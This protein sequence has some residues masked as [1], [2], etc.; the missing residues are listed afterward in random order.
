M[1]GYPAIDGVVHMDRVSFA[2]FTDSNCDYNTVAIANNPLSADA[3][4][5][6]YMTGTNKLNVGMNNLAFFYEPDP[7]WIV[8][9]VVNT[10]TLCST[11]VLFV[12][13]GSVFRLKLTK[14][15]QI[16]FISIITAFY[17]AQY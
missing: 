5:P 7:E 11:Y 2:R 14:L 13:P 12:T 15:C 17:K 1:K 6:I 8:Q 3:V 10:Y 16:S 9:E 4:H